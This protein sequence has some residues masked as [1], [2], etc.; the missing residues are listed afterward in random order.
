[1]THMPKGGVGTD[2]PGIGRGHPKGVVSDPAVLRHA[3][4]S[5]VLMALIGFPIAS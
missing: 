1:M 2:D 5:R 4:S 3:P